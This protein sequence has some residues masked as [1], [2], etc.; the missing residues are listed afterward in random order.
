[1]LVKRGVV[2]LAALTGFLTWAAVQF[3]LR[4]VNRRL[5][6]VNVALPPLVP[7]VGLAPL[8]PAVPAVPFL[9]GCA[10]LASPLAAALL[11]G[12]ALTLFLLTRPRRSA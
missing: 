12:T 7:A 4:Y 8:V 2:G 3:L 11:W 6:W 5:A 10:F 1:M 9:I